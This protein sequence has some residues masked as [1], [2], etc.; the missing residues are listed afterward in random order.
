MDLNTARNQLAL[1]NKK[2]VP[3]ITGA[4][5]YW[6]I[7]LIFSF[8]IKNE[9]TLAIIYLYGTGLLFLA[10]ILISK[11][12]KTD[13]FKKI[14]PLSGLSGILAAVPALMGPLMAYICFTDPGALPFTISVITA[15]HFFPFAWLYQSKSYIYPP[16]AM[17]ILGLAVI[18]F[19]RDIQFTAFPILMMTC[20]ALLIAG[21]CYEMKKEAERENRLDA[22]TV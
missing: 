6:F 13:M 8:V 20:L 19:A 14:N 3:M 22:D 10:G 2:G 9:S 17:L 1:N 11:W 15:G 16:S 5:L 21:A 7:M 4:L 12:M 18:L